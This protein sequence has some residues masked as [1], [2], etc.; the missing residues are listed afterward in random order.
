VIHVIFKLLLYKQGLPLSQKMCDRFPELLSGPSTRAE[1]TVISNQ[2][3]KEKGLHV[4]V[5]LNAI[6]CNTPVYSSV[7]A[8][9]ELLK[10]PTLFYPFAA[11]RQ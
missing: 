5:S 2:L 3:G 1:M 10:S 4:L 11:L 8:E 6:D 9:R 7:R